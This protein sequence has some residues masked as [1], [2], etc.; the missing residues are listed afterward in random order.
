MSRNQTHARG[1]E[2]VEKPAPVV[3]KSLELTLRLLSFGVGLLS[4]LFE[5][6][7]RGNIV[8]KAK[9]ALIHKRGIG[10]RKVFKEFWR[11]MGG[12]W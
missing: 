10:K 4:S 9:A 12:L 3:K 8:R 2:D 1:L 7:F 6:A 5:H 11:G